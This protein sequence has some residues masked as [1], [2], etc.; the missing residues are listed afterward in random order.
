LAIFIGGL[1]GVRLI[2]Q[3]NLSDNLVQH[4]GSLLLGALLS[5]LLKDCG[6][7][8]QA[9]NKVLSTSAWNGFSAVWEATDRH[10]D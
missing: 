9:N 4:L 3:P 5:R 6:D 10:L 1:H 7:G 8:K 2:L